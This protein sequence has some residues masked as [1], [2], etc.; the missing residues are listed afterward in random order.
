MP[1][2]ESRELLLNVCRGCKAP[3]AAPVATPANH[4]RTVVMTAA[5]E[6]L[7]GK[8]P[9]A[10]QAA[11]AHEVGGPNVC[12]YVHQ[13]RENNMVDEMIARLVPSPNT[14]QDEQD[15]PP[16]DDEKDRAGPSAP[17]PGPA[18]RKL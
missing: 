3:A 10:R 2:G 17:R 15:R 5:A 6:F 16:P 4:S 13:W 8:Y 14:S 9:S 1:R 7:S 12:Y 11:I 18:V